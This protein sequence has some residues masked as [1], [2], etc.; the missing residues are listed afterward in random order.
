MTDANVNNPVAAN[1]DVIEIPQVSVEADAPTPA[2]PAAAEP[3]PINPAFGPPGVA[4]SADPVTLIIANTKW[5]G[6]QRVRITR[7]MET[8]PAVFELQVTERYPT[9]GQI[10]IKPGDPCQVKIG[11][12]LAITG[13]VDRYAASIAANQ[14]TVR[15]TGRSKSADLVDCAAFVGSPENEIYQIQ[16]G[17]VLSIVQ[18]VAKGYGIEVKS[19]AGDGPK[20]NASF[21]LNLGETP[22]EVID[23]LLRY[24][25][26]VA[27]DM[28][29]GT[30]VIAQA[31]KEAH[32]SGFVQGKNVEAA[33]VTY[34][35]DQRYSIYYGYATSFIAATV[36]EGQMTTPKVQVKDEGVPRFRKRIIISEN[37]DDNTNLLERR[38]KW[39]MARRMG[40]STAIAV[41]CDSWR[42]SRGA[43]WAPNH[44]VQCE[45]P[46]L[47]APKLKW[48]IGSVTYTRDENGQHAL[49]VMMPP[50]AFQ[51]EPSVFLPLPL[52]AADI[53]AAPATS[54]PV[55]PE[56][57][58]G[59]PAV[60]ATPPEQFGPPAPQP[61]DT[62][63]PGG[64]GAGQIVPLP[65]RLP[66]G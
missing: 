48:C 56:A 8:V 63:T 49:V 19:L 5:A 4:S 64:G 65:P 18:Q 15:I 17:T 66:G 32:S 35:M 42:D 57:G 12:D 51:P 59:S 41:N 45:L 14:H 7:G 60:E 3:E 28:P 10:D 43:L 25:Q 23:R 22:W 39:E 36:Q 24:G 58:G 46:A 50:E 44:L 62:A 21:L 37:Y 13:Y 2:A 55:S 27:Y 9:S 30:M 53:G 16:P 40:R 31:G 38:V 29:D 1:S 34:S 61:S 26:F 52:T 20:I 54:N 6:W 33:E 47:K 11:D